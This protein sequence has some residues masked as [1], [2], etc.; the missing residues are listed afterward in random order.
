MST[1][2]PAS[3]PETE[4]TVLVETRGHLGIITLNRPRA[5]NAM[6]T[7][8]VRRTDAALDAFARDDAVRAVLLRG[9]GERGLCAGGDIRALHRACTEDPEQ[10]F[11]FFRA[12]YALDLRIAEHPQPVVAFMSGLVLGGGVGVSA[13]AQVRVVTETTR[14]GM[15]ETG[16]GFSP[17]VAGSWHL[18]QAPGRT[19]ELFALTG[20]HGDAADALYLGLADAYVPEERLDELARALESVADPERVADVVEGFA[21]EPPVSGLE[22]ARGWVD[23]V[24]AAQTVEQIRDGLIRRVEQAPEDELAAQALAA[25][26]RNSPTGMKTALEALRRAREMSIAA[27][28]DQDFRT[29]GHA[30]LGH[31]M[32]E[33]IR[34]QV[35]DKDRNPRWEPATLEEVTR[36]AVLGFFAPVPGQADLGLEEAPEE[37]A[38]GA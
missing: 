34:A 2:A 29:S 22:E 28:L 21:V 11:A 33:G 12:E 38:E 24:F 37:P 5:I 9:A 16:I 8:M 10:G 15:P 14:I 6:D 32:A 26:R 3:A 1:T 36:E 19:G 20:R 13:P 27:T 18:G 31:D 23:E 25:I 35:V 30:I 4:P 17:D 7:E